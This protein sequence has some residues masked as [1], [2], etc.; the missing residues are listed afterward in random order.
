MK[1]KLSAMVMATLFLASVTGLISPNQQSLAQAKEVEQKITVLNPLGTPPPIKLK[2]MAPRLDT[3]EGKTIYIVNDGYPGSGIMLKELTAVCKE[4]FPN[5]TFV[6]KDKPG[7][8]GR[9]DQAL[10]KEIDERADA[11]VI[12]L[13]H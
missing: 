8:M 13:G 11:M 10:W 1:W 9:T 2:P 5:T 4:K 7:G 12:A 6:Y 3:M